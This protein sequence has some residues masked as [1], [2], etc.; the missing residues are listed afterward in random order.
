MAHQLFPCDLMFVHRDAEA[1]DPRLRVQEICR[2]IPQREGLSHVPL[3]PV[4]M[5]EA[6]LLIDESAIR[7]A[8]DNP[9]GTIALAM[10]RNSKLEHI[11]DPKDMLRQLLITAS[12]KSGRNRRRFV[13]RIPER[14]HRMADLIEDFSPLCGLP[15]FSAFRE[16]TRIALRELCLAQ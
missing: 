9:N 4:R 10:P 13:R 1:V 3:V 16:R 14:V 12:G 6:W 2:A 15:A 8:T 7:R 5:T 11:A